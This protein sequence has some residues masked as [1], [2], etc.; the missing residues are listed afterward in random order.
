[1]QCRKDDGYTSS[2]WTLIIPRL[3]CFEKLDLSQFQLYIES[4]TMTRCFVYSNCKKTILVQA[5][6]GK[7]NV[8]CILHML[9][10]HTSLRK[11]SRTNVY[12][13][14]LNKMNPFDIGVP[15]INNAGSEPLF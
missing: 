12:D 15:C 11:L 13:L 7:E 5:A 10:I 2:S 3:P 14:H 4:Q 6:E 1:M 9:I 8:F